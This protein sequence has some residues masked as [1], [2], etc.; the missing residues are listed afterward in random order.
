MKI[1]E[2]INIYKSAFGSSEP[3]DTKL[4]ENF[5][6][7]ISIKEADGIT[8]SMLFKIPC[9]L[10]FNDEKTPIFYIYAAA[11]DKK[12]RGKGYMSDLIKNVIASTDAPLFLKPATKELE[13]IYAR[14][15]FKRITA[16][17]QNFDAFLTPDKKWEQLSSADNCPEDFILMYSGNLP[18]E[19]SKLSFVYTMD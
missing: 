9:T 17:N 14:L 13:S 3:F 7:C 19:I 10:N 15:G 1:I 11:T 12:H 16:S 5:A 2:C 6:D 18:P 8:V 4:F